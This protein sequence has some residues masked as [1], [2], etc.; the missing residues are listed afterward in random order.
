ML[1]ENVASY[2]EKETE[3][4]PL[5]EAINL[6]VFLISSRVVHSREGN[7]D[8]HFPVEGA[9]HSVRRVNPAERFQHFVLV[10][11]HMVHASYWFTNILIG[12]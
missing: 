3:R 9:G 12:S 5:V 7:L 4:N 8:T 11:V 2:L 1:I 10:F 6:Y